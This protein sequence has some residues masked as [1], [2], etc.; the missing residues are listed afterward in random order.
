[1]QHCRIPPVRGVWR[2][3]IFITPTLTMRT[4]A[5]NRFLQR[6][7]VYPKHN[8]FYQRLYMAQTR[9]LAGN[10]CAW[11]WLHVVGGWGWFRI[12]CRGWATPAVCFH[13]K[14]NCALF[15]CQVRPHEFTQTTICTQGKT[16]SPFRLYRVRSYRKEQWHRTHSSSTC[17]CSRYSSRFGIRRSA[18]A[19][20]W[21]SNRARKGISFCTPLSKIGRDT[22]IIYQYTKRTRYR[23]Y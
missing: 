1:M 5:V 12:P 19:G 9:V 4:F 13:Y 8:T 15:S 2:I 10:A 22:G 16:T 14:L 23:V 6:K 7:H 17:G 11:I 18:V 3:P 20:T 21:R